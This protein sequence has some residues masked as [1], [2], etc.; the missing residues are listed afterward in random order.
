M[1]PVSLIVLAT[2]TLVIY[3][4]A[5]IEDRRE[6][7]RLADELEAARSVQQVLIPEEIPSIAGFAIQS[8]YLPAGE[9]G[10]DFFQILPLRDDGVLVV[11]GDVSGKGCQP[12][13]T[14]YRCW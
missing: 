12:A 9:V 10:G 5:L 6:K 3:V 14:M 1:N 8:I 4:R 11:I 13:M 2:T 7:Q